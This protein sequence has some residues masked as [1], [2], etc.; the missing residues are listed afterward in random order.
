MAKPT[1]R[2]LYD[3]T[4]TQFIFECPGCGQ[5]Y[6]VAGV[7]IED[8]EEMACNDCNTVFRIRLRDDYRSLDIITIH[9]PTGAPLG[10]AETEERQ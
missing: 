6:K 1:A 2:D 7:Q 5:K 10:P 8:E 3:P 9:G 4:K